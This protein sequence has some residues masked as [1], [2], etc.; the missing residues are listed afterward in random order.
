MTTD[1]CG[2]DRP[3]AYL[4]PEEESFGSSFELQ[5]KD[6]SGGAL[7]HPFELTVIREDDQ[8]LNQDMKRVNIKKSNTDQPVLHADGVTYIIHVPGRPILPAEVD[9][10]VVGL[11]DIDL[12]F[13]LVRGHRAAFH[14]HLTGPKLHQ[15]LAGGAAG[16]RHHAGEQSSGGHDVKD[17]LLQGQRGG[18]PQ[19]V[20]HRNTLLISSL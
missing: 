13:A 3:A 18:R 17:K 12:T 1:V 16:P 6:P 20:T 8:V 10:G 14:G 5:H 19:P 7:V 4:H 11:L 9:E 15:V 2:A